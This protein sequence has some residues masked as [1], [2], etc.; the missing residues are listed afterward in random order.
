M[1]FFTS[2][3]T[4]IARIVT[5]TKRMDINPVAR[6]LSTFIVNI[7]RYNLYKRGFNKLYKTA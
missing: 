6:L 2:T 1:R 7:R 5:A 4:E 3:N